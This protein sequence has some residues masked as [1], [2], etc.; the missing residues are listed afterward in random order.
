MNTSHEGGHVYIL[1]CIFI[2]SITQIYFF[3]YEMIEMSYSIQ[4]YFESVWNCIDLPIF[5]VNVVYLVIRIQNIDSCFY[6]FSERPTI[7]H[8][9]YVTMIILNVVIIF[10]GVFKIMF[11]LRVYDEFG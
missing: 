10:S 2:S 1:I 9:Q 11:Y 6:P 5:V 3:I 7:D 4:D 8:P